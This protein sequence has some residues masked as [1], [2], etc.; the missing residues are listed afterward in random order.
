MQVFEKVAK[1]GVARI[2]KILERLSDVI[3]P[4]FCDFITQQSPKNVKF[5][6]NKTPVGPMFGQ[7]TPHY[8]PSWH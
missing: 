3:L 4:A 1:F 7:Q 8:P 5:S 2:A 6:M